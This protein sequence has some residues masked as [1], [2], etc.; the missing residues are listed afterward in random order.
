MKRHGD[1]WKTVISPE[2]IELAYKR[3]KRGKT[4]QK[5]VKRVED[6][7]DEI[8]DGVRLSLVNHTFTTSPYR[9]KKIFEPKPR[10]IYVLPF[11]PDRIVQHALMEPVAPIWNKMFDS[12]S[13]AC[14]PGFGQHSASVKAMEYVRNYKYVFQGDIQKFYP[15]INHNVALEI[16][17]RKIKDKN[18]LWLFDDIVRSMPGEKNIPIG[19]LTSQW[20]GNLYMTDFDHFAR[21]LGCHAYLRYNDDFLMFGDSKEEL[22]GWRRKSRIFLDEKLKLTLSKDRVYPTWTGVDFVG[23]RHFPEK[24][25]IRKSTA[26]RVKGRIRRLRFELATNAIELDQ[27]RSVVAATLGWMKWANAYHLRR[28]LRLDE[29]QEKI[30]AAL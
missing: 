20:I 23:Y 16:I 2:T 1:L 29:L 25:L 12:G 7:K 11:V 18:V 5:T 27:A 4:W 9:Q 14:R 6:R 17:Q 19:N 26:R 24:V 15:S 13:H 30:V 3:A 28:S 21:S 8:L 10:I 22:Q